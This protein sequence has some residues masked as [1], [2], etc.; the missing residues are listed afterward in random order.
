MS[1]D[2]THHRLR[3]G[4]TTLHVATAGPR[5][6]QPVLLIHG[7][8]QT[9]LAWR[10]LIPR[11]DG[12]RLVM[13][14][15]RGL[16][17]SG[18]NGAGYD[19]LSLARDLVGLTE[20]MELPDTFVVG[21]DW[22][23]VVAFYTTW[24]L[25]QRAKGLAVLD[26]TIPNDLGSGTDI[27]QGGK[28][29]HHGFNRS[30]LAERLVIGREREYYGWF[31]ETLGRAPDVIDPET[32]EAYVDAY[33][34]PECSRAGFELYRAIATDIDNAR[35]VGRHG[36]G[37]PVLALGGDSSW[38]RGDEPLESLSHFA[39]DVTGGSVKD[40]GHWIPEERPAELATALTEFF[41]HCDNPG[42][43]D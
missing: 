15:L 12:Y 21:H 10:H 3:T 11:L 40:C 43:S 24:L 41:T 28:R 2:V 32:I 8:P 23:G 20:V 4:D 14:D 37:V 42:E 27:A 39:T 5:D 25:E 38:G 17:D 19:K 34:D 13:P 33:R 35:L 26:V 30:A 9:W 36:I 7:W 18:R 31:Y 22:G 1:D 29:W 16:G 6:G